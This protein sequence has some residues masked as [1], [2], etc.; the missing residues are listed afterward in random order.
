[1]FFEV[2]GELFRLL[3]KTDEGVWAISYDSPA[4]PV[5]LSY[6]AFDACKKVPAPINYGA[7]KP[8][9]EAQER[10][11][12]LI[13]P[14]LEN[15][16]CIT[17]NA[18]RRDAAACA[19]VQ[20]RTTARRVLRLYYMYLAKETVG[21]EREGAGRP[22]PEKYSDFKWA[23]ETFYFSAKRMPLRMAYDLMLTQRYM[24]DGKLDQNAPT[25]DS[26][27]H[28]YYGRGFHRRIRKS[29]TREGLSNYQR[30]QRLLTGSAMAWK[31]R[32]GAFQMDATEA[33]I[34][35]VS[36]FDRSAVIGRPYIYLAVD[37]ATQLIAGVYVGLKS[38]EEAVMACLAN[39]AGDKVQFCR[40]YGIE[41]QPEQWPNTGLP[42]EIIT[43]QGREFMGSRIDE[44]CKIY[45][46][47]REALPPFR[48]DC[49]GLVEKTFDLIQQ[50]YKPLL[51][52]KGV[53]EPDAQERWAV[54]YRSQAA[55]D[56]NEF[57][58]VIIQCII[59]INSRHMLKGFYPTAELFQDE[60]QPTPAMIWLWYE[61]MGRINLIPVDN[62]EIYQMTLT[63][64]Q[65]RL[66]RKGVE[67]EGLYYL[68]DNYIALLQEYGV[69]KDVTVG[70]DIDCLDC[71]YLIDE[72]EYIP[73]FLASR[74]AQYQG[75]S[76][77]E[78]DLLKEK[79]RQQ[80]KNLQKQENEARAALFQSIREIAENAECVAKSR[81]D[82]TT[83][84]ENRMEERRKRS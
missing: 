3:L 32:I 69:G 23:I 51:R 59:Y 82:G 65:G 70:F 6:S 1:M 58:I 34:Y 25:W 71:I 81:Q 18:V 9:T 41:I 76:E 67:H 48:P 26:F 10:R 75:I 63:R 43:D 11:L 45:G 72:G 57:T 74:Y 36:R 13:T 7:S 2:S 84:K 78:Y 14:L 62:D 64:T 52:G 66:T 49:K 5:F 55:L 8:L 40:K 44:L 77:M 21:G 83:I 27:R 37:V 15:T 20:N 53:I 50:K 22:D 80:K 30:N 38:G 39:A 56:L 19:A 42:G 61:K 54:D 4:A 68:S 29:V 60:V 31:D 73:L 46:M 35:L 16:H 24:K 28:Y 47:E 12:R 17:D 33:D 79:M